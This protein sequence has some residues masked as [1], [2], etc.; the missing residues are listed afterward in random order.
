MPVE[1]PVES[2]PPSQSFAVDLD[3]QIYRFEIV[4]NERAEAWSLS[5][6]QPDETPIVM[7]VRISGS[8]DLLEHYSRPELPPGNLLS[9]DMGGDNEPPGRFD[10]GERVRLIYFGADENG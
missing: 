4:W 2:A 9:V 7:G 6:L 10:L 8:W 3:G 5:I 1:L